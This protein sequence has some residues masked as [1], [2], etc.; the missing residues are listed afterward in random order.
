MGGG[1]D[2]ASFEFMVGEEEEL[3]VVFSGD[4]RRCK[5]GGPFSV[6]SSEG[7]LEIAVGWSI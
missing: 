4:R 7:L 2:V 3:G 5:F 1:S 6:R